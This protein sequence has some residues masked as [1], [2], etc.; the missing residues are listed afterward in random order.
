VV[1]A[2]NQDGRLM[3]T[4]VGIGRG[5]DGMGRVTV[6]WEPLAAASS[7]RGEGARVT[8]T[9]NRPRAETVFESSPAD[10]TSTSPQRVSFDAGA[11]AL[12]VRITVADRDGGTIDRET[13]V[14]EVPDYAK[15]AASLGTPKFYRARTARE[16][17]AFATDADATPIAAREFART[18]RLLIKFDVYAP[19][20]QTASP[21]A[22]ILNRAG[23]KMFDVPV[24]L[25][26][27]GASHQIDLTL[28][29]LPV[30]EYLLEVA[31][32]A[33]GP[34]QLAAFRVR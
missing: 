1:A 33:N 3:Q 5:A 16:F 25:A 31:T 11:G 8:I 26:T 12:E 34:K 2:P 28:S 18:D 13:R 7:A 10:M 14:V 6:V 19:D 30:G 27:A 17:Q 32:A 15:P 4:W 22:A 24:G 9:A 20:G 23:R 29:P 21:G